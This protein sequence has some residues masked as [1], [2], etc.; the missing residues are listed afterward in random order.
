VK[1]VVRSLL[2]GLR[3]FDDID[4]LKERL[5]ELPPALEDLY[6][7]MLEK[8]SP[9]YR[10]Q[11][12]KLIQIVRHN[13]M[14][15]DSPLPTLTLY[16]A[17]DKDEEA[18][19]AAPVERLS[20]DEMYKRCREMDIKLRTR[21][22]GLLEV[23]HKGYSIQDLSSTNRTSLEGLYLAESHVQFLH[24]S[25]TDFLDSL[26]PSSGLL[27][28]DDPDFN[29]NVSL[30]RGYLM[31]LKS[32][33]DTISWP[34]LRLATTFARKAEETQLHDQT[35]LVDQL[36][37]VMWKLQ[38][39]T[40]KDIHW[41]ES[42]PE[43]QNPIGVHHDSYLSFC[44]QNGLY[45]YVEAAFKAHGPGLLEKP[46]R[47]LLDYVLCPWQKHESPVLVC[48]AELVQLL[49][50][51]GAN[52]TTKYESTKLHQRFANYLMK[53]EDCGSYACARSIRIFNSLLKGGLDAKT[54]FKATLDTR[55]GD[56]EERQYSLLRFVKMVFIEREASP[57]AEGL[58]PQAWM[59]RVSFEQDVKDAADALVGR[60]VS[61]GGKDKEW[62]NSRLVHSTSSSGR[63][64]VEFSRLKD[65]WKRKSA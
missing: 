53:T 13:A 47:P 58:M 45:Y 11:A 2:E 7:H 62:R 5:R 39:S 41:S 52:V 18:A 61:L 63:L 43:N 30:L 31:Q 32:M 20:F 28:I 35:A 56:K 44:I 46:G 33:H 3:A 19:I 14:I 15:Y 57:S 60:V 37:M 42:N 23:Q 36:D 9:R 1:L 21:T 29:P 24:K 38:K 12:S 49:V 16:S 48:N 4:D 65:A 55:T 50:S 8:V 10:A 6:R 64:K 25:V 34:A 17:W 40:N 22:S 59:T 26:E 54:T 27:S 51:Y